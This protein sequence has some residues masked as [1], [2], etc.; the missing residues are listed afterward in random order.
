MHGLLPLVSIES[1]YVAQVDKK[2]HEFNTSA[3]YRISQQP[4]AVRF[5]LDSTLDSELARKADARY[6]VESLHIVLVYMFYARVKELHGWNP[7]PVD[8]LIP[9]GITQVTNKSGALEDVSPSGNCPDLAL[10]SWQ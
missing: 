2:H 9:T 10:T 3:V 6:L 5:I 4:G 8:K 7:L 1:K